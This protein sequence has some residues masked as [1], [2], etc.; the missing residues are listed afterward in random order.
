LT[1]DQTSDADVTLSP[2]V[3]ISIFSNVGTDIL[4]PIAVT[5][6]GH[7][8]NDSLGKNTFDLSDFEANG[9][10]PFEL[11]ELQTINDLDV[12]KSVLHQPVTHSMP[13]NT[14]GSIAVASAG[15]STNVTHTS[16][17]GSVAQPPH[18]PK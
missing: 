2:A 12:L 8:R 14:T 6:T 5:A 7:K 13:L 10:N 1:E 16:A 15:V 3:P 18:T 4:Q 9:T 11:V 17:M